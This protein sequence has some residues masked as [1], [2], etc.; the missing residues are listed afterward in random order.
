MLGLVVGV[1]IGLAW[2]W[3]VQP[4][5]YAGGAYPNELSDFYQLQYVQAVSEAYLTTRDTAAAARR[6]DKFNA[7]DKVKW[8]ATVANEFKTQGRTTE[9]SMVGDLAS[10]LMTTEGWPAEAVSDGLKAAGASPDFA[11]KLGQVPESPAPQPQ[12]QATP[13]AP[14]AEK[15]GGAS[16]MRLVVIVLIIILALVLAALLLRRLRKPAKAPRRPIPTEVVQEGGVS[17]TPLRQWVGTY[18]FGQDNY[19]ESFTI[20]TPESD[21]LGEC[22]MGIMEGFASGTPRRVLAFDVWLFDKTDI[23]TISTAVMSKFAFEDEKLRA[24]LGPDVTPILATE[25]ATFDIETTALLVKARIEEVTYGEGP[26]EMSYF[27][28]LKI[29]L[30]AY[31]RPNVDVSGDM[32]IP[33][34]YA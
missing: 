7:A 34:G 29:S 20:E 11:A 28:T 32:P 3:L 22:G 21:F 15:E 25:G 31:L 4:A 23:R 14:P 27:N 6:L 33:E 10:A 8:L 19:D 18:T 1:S 16:P 13:A 9:A 26:P 17:L 2:A 30:S 12:A 24:K 5:Y